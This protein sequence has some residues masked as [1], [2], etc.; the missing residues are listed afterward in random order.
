MKYG[1]IF[2]FNLIIPMFLILLLYSVNTVEA[3]E[4]YVDYIPG[5]LHGKCEACHSGKSLD[6]Y[7]EDFGSVSGHSSDPQRAINLI[8]NLDSDGDGYTNSIE[9]GE[10]TFPGDPGSYP[11]SS[12]NGEAQFLPIALIG[13]LSLIMVV[14]VLM[15]NKGYISRDREQDNT[16]EKKKKK[17]KRDISIA[18]DRKNQGLKT[19]LKNLDKDYKNGTLDE[20]VYHD[21][22]RIYENKIYK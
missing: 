19:A 17:E 6:F 13:L 4:M 3:K 8:A 15:Y 5:P 20:E 10:G 1:F 21:L 18:D 9:L 22:K 11:K 14:I 16:D 12:R 2:I 7:G